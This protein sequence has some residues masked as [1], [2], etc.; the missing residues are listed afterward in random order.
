M[1]HRNVNNDVFNLLLLLPFLLLIS[2]VFTRSA[3]YTLMIEGVPKN[4]D[5]FQI[6][7]FSSSTVSEHFPRR[8]MTEFFGEWRTLVQL[9]NGT[10]KREWWSFNPTKQTFGDTLHFLCGGHSLPC[11]SSGL[12]LRG[13]S[14]DLA[15]FPYAGR[16]RRHRGAGPQPAVTWQG[17]AEDSGEVLW[18]VGAGGRPFVPRDFSTAAR[19]GMEGSSTCD[20]RCSG[21][22]VAQ[23]KFLFVFYF[24]K[25]MKRALSTHTPLGLWLLKAAPHDATQIFSLHTVRLLKQTSDAWLSGFLA[26]LFLQRPGTAIP[27]RV[28]ASRT[29]LS[30]L[31][32]HKH[33]EAIRGLSRDFPA[34]HAR[35]AGSRNCLSLLFFSYSYSAELWDIGSLYL[36]K[37]VIF[38]FT[39]RAHQNCFDGFF[40]SSLA[41]RAW[42]SSSL[43]ECVR[44]EVL[45]YTRAK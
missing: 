17:P 29:P 31:R 10:K 3:K 6:W 16:G 23:L 41:H 1:D 20:V 42:T 12:Q 5:H 8:K 21:R 36:V 30:I 40:Y 18:R 34:F 19:R 22:Q 25:K 13:L 7:L 27:P 26:A 11:P 45:Y 43:G 15:A 32:P 24:G 38:D 44:W 4:Q 14:E 35:A 28:H 2:E 37:N 9:L 39:I 33:G